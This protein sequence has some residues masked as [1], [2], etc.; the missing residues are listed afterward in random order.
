MKYEFVVSS[1]AVAI[2]RGRSAGVVTR[3]PII[4]FAYNDLGVWVPI[5]AFAE[6]DVREP[7]PEDGKYEVQR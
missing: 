7:E 3:R 1:N 6:G 2:F 4:A 5:I